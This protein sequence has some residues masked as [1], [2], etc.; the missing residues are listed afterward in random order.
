M[1]TVPASV[2]L[3][4]LYFLM[5][6]DPTQLE[7]RQKQAARNALSSALQEIWDAWWWAE[8]MVCEPL[9]GAP[10]YDPAETVSAQAV[11]YYPATRK[12]YQAL[13]PTSGNAPAIFDTAGAYETNVGI[14]ALAELNY[15]GPDYKTQTYA[16]GTVV[17]YPADDRFYECIQTTSFLTVA[18]AGFDNPINTANG[19][20][21]LSGL[22][23]NGKP[24]YSNVTKA[25]C[26]MFWDAT[27][28]VVAFGGT[29]L[30]T[31][32][33]DVPTPDLVSTWTAAAPAYAP[34]PTVTLTYV[35]PTDPNY[36]CV[37]NEFVPTIVFNGMLRMAS[38]AD[39]RATRNPTPLDTEPVAEGTRV[40]GPRQG[41]FWAWYRRPTPI[42]TADDF[43]ETL[44]Y[45]ATPP[46][47]L[48]FDS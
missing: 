1:Q 38:E 12:Y 29:Y 26:S 14:W 36:W 9:P 18:G 45:A 31:A 19:I 44:S 33:D 2:I 15:C 28:W 3:D 6:W 24:G 43:D 46:A 21:K 25:G 8:L 20:Y 5:E 37:L 11:R 32:P 41:T 27:Q 13:K 10:V 40:H 22:I 42:I 34:A 35:D 16:T 17:R 4:D 23:V 47:D 39:P 48:V 30:Y 7:D